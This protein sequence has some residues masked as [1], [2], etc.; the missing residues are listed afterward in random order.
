MDDLVYELLRKMAK[1]GVPWLY[2]HGCNNDWVNQ[3][4]LEGPSL[5]FHHLSP[6]WLPCFPL[7]VSV[8][9]IRSLV[10]RIAKLDH[11]LIPMLSN[12]GLFLQG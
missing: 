4:F 7:Q 5:S 12:V 9:A 2:I 11:D 1:G 3:K 10:A 8:T 6:T